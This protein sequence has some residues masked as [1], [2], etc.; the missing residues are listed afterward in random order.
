MFNLN[1]KMNVATHNLT[2]IP[3]CEPARSAQ[4]LFL[5]QLLNNSEGIVL[6]HHRGVVLAH[7]GASQTLFKNFPTERNCQD[8]ASLIWQ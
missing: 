7:Q 1:Y 2:K 5:F 8:Q 3:Q 4:I 6:A